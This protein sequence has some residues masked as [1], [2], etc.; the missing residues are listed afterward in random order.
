[1]NKPSYLPDV[2]KHF[3]VSQMYEIMC[4]DQI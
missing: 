4:N 1:M 2:I 3:F